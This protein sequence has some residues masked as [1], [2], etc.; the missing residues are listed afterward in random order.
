MGRTQPCI[1]LPPASFRRNVRAKDAKQT[2]NNIIPRLLLTHPRAQRG[3]DATELLIEPLQRDQD[4]KP[5]GE[6]PRLSLQVADTLTAAHS[7]LPLNTNGSLDLKNRLCRVAILNMAS[8]LCAGGGV[9]KGANSQEESLCRRTT[10]LPAL[11]DD[12]YRLPELGAVYTPDVLVFRDELGD[13]I[14]EK[15]DRWF[16]DCITAAMLRMPDCQHEESGRRV[17][18]SQKDRDLAL[19]KMNMVLRVCEAKGVQRLV[20]G[21]WGCGAYGNPVG[22]IAAAW[23]KALGLQRNNRKGGEL[24]L[25]KW[26]SIE[27]IVFAIKDP[28]MA[29]QFAAEFGSDLLLVPPE[30]D[31]GYGENES[32]CSASSS[33]SNQTDP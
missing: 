15:K 26:K 11:K 7:L 6:G 22:E 12:F 9:L 21:A 16:V 3:I 4:T 1:V 13:K 27:E 19:A 23:H 5:S 30:L 8:P 14:L 2:V 24:D 20:L 29:T 32:S 28:I 17:Y 25:S 10:L 33:G 18:E 31:D